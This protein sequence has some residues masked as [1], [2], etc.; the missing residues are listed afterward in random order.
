MELT[1][2][3]LMTRA[4]DHVRHPRTRAVELAELRARFALAPEPS[5]LPARQVERAR[6]LAALRAEMAAA[7]DGVVACGG[8]G[9]GHELPEGRWDG[10]FCCA[11]RTEEL[12]DDL[13]VAVLKA[14]GTRTRD[15]RAP[16]GDH[17]GCA[18]RGPAGCS[19]PAVHRPSRCL[20]YVC[21]ELRLELGRAGRLPQIEAL[22][23]AL[24]ETEQRFA[25][26]LADQL[27]D[28]EW[29][30]VEWLASHEP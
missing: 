10:G 7:L 21:S 28:E 3:E 27:E 16:S 20:R 25:A 23:E 12:F 6:R 29:R 14:A 8:C 26:D 9:R 18:F 5:R 13:E 2:R 19:L 1:L 11:G 17:A 15:L 30:L 22:G 4:A 24:R